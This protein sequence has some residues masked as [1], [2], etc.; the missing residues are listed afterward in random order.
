L[1]TRRAQGF[2]REFRLLRPAQYG[3]V[4]DRALRS[5]DE[6]LTVLARANRTGHAR[7]GLAIAKR[8]ARGAVQRNRI[9][10][11]IRESFRIR[12]ADLP[13]LDF[14]VLC[15]QTAV[16]STNETLAESLDRHWRRLSKQW[17]RNRAT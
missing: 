4:F 14:V 9:K 13:A 10:R 17:Y 12:Q 6:T 16:D 5:S 2:S 15:H 11:L 7:L 8:C 1:S 3:R